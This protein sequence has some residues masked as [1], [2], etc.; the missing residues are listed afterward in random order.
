M[1]THSSTTASHDAANDEQEL[2][3]LAEST[4]SGQES[5]Q[6]T[7]GNGY[8]PN[9]DIDRLTFGFLGGIGSPMGNTLYQC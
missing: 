4:E 1:S 2:I 7:P 9:I 6:K 5:Q 8:V 3:P